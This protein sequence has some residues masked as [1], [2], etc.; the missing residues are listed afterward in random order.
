MGD[1]WAEGVHK[2]D[3]D[4][5]LKNYLE[6]FRSR[7]PFE[8]EYRLRRFDGEYRWIHDFGRPFSDLDGNFAGYIGSCYD[9]TE[10]KLSEEKLKALLKEKE[11]LLREVYHRVKNNFQIIASLLNLQSQSIHDEQDLK[12]FK[13]S[14]DRLRMM[15]LIHEKLYQS[16]DLTSIDFADY[17]RTLA[18]QLFHSYNADPTCI[19]LSIQAE[20][21]SLAVDSAIP[22]GLI[23][24]E[25]VSNS[26]KYAFPPGWNGKGTI[27]VALHHKQDGQIELSVA[28][29]GV[30]LPENFDIQK[31]QSLGLHLVTILSEDQLHGKLDV[32]RGKGAKFVVLFSA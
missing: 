29:N 6:S 18:T 16:K 28:D 7:K 8:M 19:N 13:E 15:S 23:I 9:I 22:C 26:L 25:L 2:D 31:T 17:I 10:Q 27:E 1:G 14:Q 11:V 5:C 4:G 20:K 24:N 30:G 3:L 21:V 32:F 12:L